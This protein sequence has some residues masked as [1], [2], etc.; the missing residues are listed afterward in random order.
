[1]T[2]IG[3]R[4]VVACALAAVLLVSPAADVTHGQTATKPN[5]VVVMIDDFDLTSLWTLVANGKMPNLTKYIVTG[6]A[7]F[8]EAFSANGLGGPSRATFLTGQYAHNHGVTWGFPPR[9]LTLLD[10]SSTVATWLQA[11]GYRTGHVGRYLTGYGWWTSKTRIP[12]GWHDW[13]TLIDPSSNNTEQYE[14]NLNGTVV[15]FGQIAT[16]LGVQLHQV[17]IL[18]LLAT[19]FVKRESPSDAPFFLTLTPGVFNPQVEPTYNVCPGPF[20]PFYDEFFG[21]SIY[22][23][24][25]APATRHQGTIF[26]DSTRFPLPKSYSFNESDITDKP[27][28]VQYPEF[29][30]QPVI[31]CL[32]KRYWRKLEGML[33]VDD[34]IGA[35]FGELEKNGELA[36]TVAIFTGDNGWLDGQH[37]FSG[38]GAPYEEAIRVPLIIRAPSTGTQTRLIT[39]LVLNTDLAPTIATFAQATASHAVDGRSLVPL[40]QNP[41]L[42]WRKIALLEY[43]GDRDPFADK[44][45]PPSYF[46]VRTDRTRPTMYAR[47]PTVLA[48]LEGEFYDLAQDPYQLNNQYFNSAR[49]A[50]KSRLEQWLNLM[51]SCHGTGCQ[52]LEN[53]FTF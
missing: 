28:W 49:Q 16:Q 17:D 4:V 36:N 22:G 20:A 10:E 11:A 53:Y 47:Y 9:D 41:D 5:I 43:E 25:Q 39:K 24:S 29:F 23:A 34:M 40:L 7:I 42:A 31:D 46:A 51:K 18:S 15:D 6:G 35:V 12:A 32:E 30:S 3:K 48:G 21:G 44:P 26:G 50:E 13:K 2:S 19:D 8:S 52:I 1:M 45:L 14:M 38:K 33:A 37:R 27:V